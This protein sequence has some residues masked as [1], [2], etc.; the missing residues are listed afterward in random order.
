MPLLTPDWFTL[1]AA[2]IADDSRLQGHFLIAR[3]GDTELETEC[4]ELIPVSCAF[5][6]SQIRS[7]VGVY[8]FPFSDENLSTAFPLESDIARGLRRDQQI[9]LA[10][11]AVKERI[12]YDLY[13]MLPGADFAAIAANSRRA[14][15]DLI[16]ALVA[17]L[18]ATATAIAT[19]GQSRS[20]ARGSIQTGNG[21]YGKPYDD[22]PF[23]D[24]VF[25]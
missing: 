5:L 4:A 12:I 25:D 19:S 21:V 15:D 23:R 18:G 7:A 16:S 3:D 14:A 24:L 11:E 6:I 10:S 17:D 1:S 22:G 2:S 9:G 13:R 8:G 20:R